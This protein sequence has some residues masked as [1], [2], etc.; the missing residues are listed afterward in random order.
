MDKTQQNVVEKGKEKL[1]QYQ[2]IYQQDEIYVTI[3]SFFNLILSTQKHKYY[4][5]IFN[6]CKIK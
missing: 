5:F 1:Q 2:H 3:G 4:E 6:S